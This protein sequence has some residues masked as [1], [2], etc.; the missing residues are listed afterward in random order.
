MHIRRRSALIFALV[1]GGALVVAGVAMATTS[2]FTFSFSPSKVPKKTYKAGALSSNLVTTTR[3]GKQRPGRCRGA[4]P[5]VSS[6]RTGRSILRRL[7]KCSTQQLAGKTMKE[8]MRSAARRRSARAPRRPTPT[9]RSSSRAASCCSTAS[10]RVASQPCRSL[11]ASRDPTRA[12][13]AARTRRATR[14]ATERFCSPVCSRMRVRLTAKCST[15]TTSRSRRRS[16]SR[17]STRSI[18]KG[19]YISARCKAA[20]KTW[21]MKVIWTYNNNAK[22]IVKR[23]QPCQV[24]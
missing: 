23:T 22:R 11:R 5:A 15:S 10:Q 12:L 21:N 9:A 8:A 18:K 24:G 2:S 7:P 14:R 19:N 20:N 1:A 16:P 3:A 4:D 13:S 17:S 6:T